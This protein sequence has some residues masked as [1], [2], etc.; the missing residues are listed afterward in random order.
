M[1]NDVEDLKRIVDFFLKIKR[2]VDGMHHTWMLLVQREKKKGGVGICILSVENFL[3][4][5]Y[6]NHQ[7]REEK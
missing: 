2:I 4:F 3:F 1:E 6:F 5:Q 7:T